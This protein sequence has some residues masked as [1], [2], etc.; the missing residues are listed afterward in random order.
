MLRDYNTNLF[1]ILGRRI[2]A[3]MLSIV[4]LIQ[5]GGLFETDAS[6]SAPKH[7][8]Q[9]IKENYLHCRTRWASSARWFLLEQYADFAGLQAARVLADTLDRATSTSST[10]TAARAAG[11]VPSTTAARTY[12]ALYWAQELARQTEDAEIAAAFKGLAT[13]A[14]NESAI[15]AELLAVQG[16]PANIG[17]YYLPDAEKTRRR[18]AFPRRPSTTRWPICKQF[19][20][21]FFLVY[22]FRRIADHQVA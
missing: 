22:W 21:F 5:G 1:P 3:K 19:V 7:V 10:R 9:L 16:K 8:Q 20:F 6:S 4:P 11:S 13:L 2:E 12:M 14:A 18:D 17:G 15:V